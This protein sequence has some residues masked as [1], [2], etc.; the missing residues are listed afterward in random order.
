LME[1]PLDGRESVEKQVASESHDRGTAWGD[2]VLSLEKK[3]A[4]QEFIDRKSGFELGETGDE[5]GGEIGGLVALLL[6]A[7]MVGAQRSELIG[8]GHTAAAVAGVALAA[9]VG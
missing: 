1:F 7:G 2:A 6:A 3:E 9:S 8:D 4:R 5:F